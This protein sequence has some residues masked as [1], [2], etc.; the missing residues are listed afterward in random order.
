MLD[1]IQV[2]RATLARN[3]KIFE[4]ATESCTASGIINRIEKL[5]LQ[6]IRQVDDDFTRSAISQRELLENGFKLI[7]ESDVFGNGQSKSDVG[8]S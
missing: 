3:K 5:W 7:K 1:T 4:N 2:M 6:K 8:I